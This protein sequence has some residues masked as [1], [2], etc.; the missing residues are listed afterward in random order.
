MYGNVVNSIHVVFSNKTIRS[1]LVKFRY[2]IFLIFFILMIPQIEPSLFLSGFLVSLFGELIQLWGFAS[3]DKNRTLVFKGPY[4]LTRNPIY[5]GRFFLLL[6]GLLFTGNICI[7]LIFPVLYYFYMINRVKR[8]EMRLHF[9]FG[10]AYEYYCC[11]VNRFL[12]SF[13]RL[14][15]KS[16]WFFKY[17]LLLKNSGHWNLVALFS[18]YAIFCFFLLIKAGSQ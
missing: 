17:K 12:P 9:L 16:L 5:I 18:C 4:S 6:G 13:K 14:N 3:L 7:I 2:P 10:Q 15:W 8:E 1:F 11:Q